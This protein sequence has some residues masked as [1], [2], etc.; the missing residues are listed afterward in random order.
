[1]GCQVPGPNCMCHA[2]GN[3]GHASMD[4]LAAG[5]VAK[6]ER[7]YALFCHVS[8]VQF[9]VSVLQDEADGIARETA[10][11]L[12][13][14]QASKDA[15]ERSA[16]LK[17]RDWS[18]SGGPFS[19]GGACIF[20]MLNAVQ[21]GSWGGGED[22]SCPPLLCLHMGVVEEGRSCSSRK[23]PLFHPTEH[24]GQTGRRSGADSA[25]GGREKVSQ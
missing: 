20:S 9:A 24:Q 5:L 2:F 16:I 6:Q 10:T 22:A 4:D 8:D 7:V 11:L 12:E 21:G 3:A 18:S 25:L 1:M 17:A 13:A 14:N 15:E 19:H 23:K